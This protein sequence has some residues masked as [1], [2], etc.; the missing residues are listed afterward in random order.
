MKLAISILLIHLGQ[1]VWASPFPTSN[2]SLRAASAQPSTKRTPQP[3]NSRDWVHSENWRYNFNK[4]VT[5]WHDL[6]NTLAD[7]GV[8]HVSRQIAFTFIG[9]SPDYYDEEDLDFDD[10]QY[11][12][13]E[14]EADSE[15]EDE[16]E[17][18]TDGRQWNGWKYTTGT[19]KP[20]S[21]A[22]SGKALSKRIQRAL[23]IIDQPTDLEFTYGKA[24]LLGQKR[25]W[26]WGMFQCDL[27]IIVVT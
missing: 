24:G 11:D 14:S 7:P 19:Y 23:E 26:V 18:E 1:V 17:D 8:P 12:T 25:V 21:P 16:D 3:L 10:V 2:R 9:K 27:G 22:N 6:Q 13:S 5:L 15:G 20:S 4:G